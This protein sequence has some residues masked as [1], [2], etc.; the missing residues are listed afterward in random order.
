MSERNGFIFYRSFY[1]AIKEL[2]AENQNE[3]FLA[4]CSYSFDFLEPELTG[5]SKTIFTLIKPQLDANNRRFENGSKAKNKQNESKTEAKNKQNESKTETKEKE[6]E[7]EKDN[8]K[9]KRKREKENK[10]WDQDSEFCEF[11]DIYGRIKISIIFG[12]S[13]VQNT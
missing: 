7:K 9:E 1:E 5:L 2:P 8:V 4:I 13:R 10:Y 6:K 11:L 3:L 12:W